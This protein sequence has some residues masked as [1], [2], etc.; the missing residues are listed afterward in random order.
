MLK[1]LSPLLALSCAAWLAG[2]A[3]TVEPVADTGRDKAVEQTSISVPE[4]SSRNIVLDVRGSDVSTT[5]PDWPRLKL[6][7]HEAMDQAAADANASFTDESGTP[8]RADRAGTLVEVYVND[9]H[10]MAPGARY[11]LGMMTGN[12]FM[13]ARVTFRDLRTGKVYGERHYNTSSSAWQGIFAPV[14]D[15]QTRALAKEIVSQI[16]PR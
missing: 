12:A 7:W 10:F 5:A 15:K 4:K 13:D 16:N 3:A 2:C 9:F 14:T 6:E 1:Q 8:A 11:A